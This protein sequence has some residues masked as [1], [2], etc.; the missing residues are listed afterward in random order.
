MDTYSTA[1]SPENREN[2][3]RTC[4][5]YRRCGLVYGRKMVTGQ[6][7]NEKWWL[8]CT[9]STWCMLRECCVLCAARGHRY[10]DSRRPG[11]QVQN[12]NMAAFFLFPNMYTS[13]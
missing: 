6:S 8:Y 5:G 9:S 10:K 12:E 2:G 3:N 4:I 13:P 11:G 7:I 1:H